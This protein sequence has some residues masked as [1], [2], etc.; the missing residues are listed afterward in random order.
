VDARS[1]IDVMHKAE[2][3]KCNL[4]HSWTSSGRRESV[5]EH[6]WRLA[7]MAYFVKD[8]FPEADMNKVILMCLCHDLGEA[9]TGDIPSFI[10]TDA[11]ED[12]EKSALDVFLGSLPS[13]YVEELSALFK[14]MYALNTLE[15]RIYKA[16][17]K[18]EVL[19]QHNEADLSTWLPLEY[20]ENLTYGRSDVL[21]SEYLKSLRQEIGRD[22]LNKLSQN[23][24]QI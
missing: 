13:P 6:S 12:A 20:N 2:T 4:R 7:L 15:S 21:F 10:K 5:A 9:F 14:E 17:D 18:M 3:L 16:L 11:D 19:I 24:K 23:G 1:L 8:E 22:C